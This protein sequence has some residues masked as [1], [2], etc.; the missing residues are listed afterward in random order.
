MNNKHP[1]IQTLEMKNFALGAK[2]LTKIYLTACINLFWPNSSMQF[3]Y[4][5]IQ[6]VFHYLN[7][8]FKFWI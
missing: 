4:N 7:L 1:T 8:A 3:K 6:L 5:Y 2:D